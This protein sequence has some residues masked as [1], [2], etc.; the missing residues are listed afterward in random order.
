MLPYGCNACYDLVKEQI[1]EG[2][3]EEQC[4]NKTIREVLLSIG[5]SFSSQTDNQIRFDPESGLIYSPAHFTWMDTNYPAGTPRQGYPIEIQALWHRALRFFA[6][7]DQDKKASFWLKLSDKVKNSIS[8]LYYIKN[9]G[10]LSDCLHTSSF[11]PAAFAE[12]DDAL[13]P[14]QLLAI[15]LGAIEDK[16]I[17]KMILS[18]CEELI[19]PGAIRSLADRQVNKPIEILLQGKIINNPY[20]PYQGQYKGDEDTQRKPAYHNGTAWTW[21]FP[22][23]CEAWVHTYGEAGKKTALSILSSSVLLINQGC[24]GHVP[25][26]LDGDRPHIQR[27]CDAQAWGVSEIYRVLK[28]LSG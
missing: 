17:C 3:L 20:Y 15:T 26:I 13:R 22:S 1:N 24:V 28:K 19:V 12:P 16:N 9:L 27:G 14:N 18:S 25:E 5:K 2:F 10:F 21:L 4:G 23:F 8:E 11:K 7:I 6:V